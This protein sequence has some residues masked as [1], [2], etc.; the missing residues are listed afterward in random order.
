LFTFC[1]LDQAGCPKFE[2]YHIKHV[3]SA[4][5]DAVDE[6]GGGTREMVLDVKIRFGC[7]NNSGSESTKSQVLHFDDKQGKV[8]FCDV[9]ACAREL[10]GLGFH[11]YFCCVEKRLK[12]YRRKW[13]M[14]QG[15]F[16]K[17]G[18]FC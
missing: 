12:G 10:Y 17:Y 15:R 16:S 3:T 11:G 5:R 6:M 2:T 7:R 13:K 14:F 8:P 1:V 4:A 18:N 9:E